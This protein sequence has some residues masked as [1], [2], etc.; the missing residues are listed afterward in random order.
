[1]KENHGNKKVMS[2]MGKSP[3]HMQHH[4]LLLKSVWNIAFFVLRTHFN[5]PLPF[6]QIH[7]GSYM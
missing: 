3:T 2:P 4:G 1:V 5:T 7:G 6:H